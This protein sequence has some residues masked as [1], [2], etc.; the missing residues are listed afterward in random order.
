MKEVDVESNKNRMKV[1][2]SD[3][4]KVR[5]PS[6]DGYA[7]AI[8]DSDY[9][10]PYVLFLDDDVTTVRIYN[11]EAAK[12]RLSYTTNKPESMHLVMTH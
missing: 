12:Q 2:I 11:K 4:Y 10:T 1:V 3:L 8:N 9:D 7:I 6:G 5:G